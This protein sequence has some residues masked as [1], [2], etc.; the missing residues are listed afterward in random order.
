MAPAYRSACRRSGERGARLCAA[1]VLRVGSLG[2][3][4][5]ADEGAG[6]DWRQNKAKLDLES[7]STKTLVLSRK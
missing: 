2:A 1:E 5:L 4:S 6:D 7:G 3:E